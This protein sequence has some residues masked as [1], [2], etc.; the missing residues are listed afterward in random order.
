MIQ[1]LP[2]QVPSTFRPGGFL[3]NRLAGKRIVVTGATG[4]AAAG[5][6]AFAAEGAHVFVI[7][8]TAESC[9]SLVESIVAGG[10][11]AKWAAA[12]LTDEE[13]AVDAFGAA[14]SEL[15]GVDGLYAV[16]GGSG[17]RFGDGP[18]DSVPLDGWNETLSLNGRPAFLAAREAIRSMLSGRE[19]DPTSTGSIAI[20]SSV[21]AFAPSPEMFATHAYAAIKG[22]E[23]SLAVSMAAYYAPHGIRVNIVAPGLV[24]TPM[25]A[26]AA[27]D[28]G[29][30]SFAERKQPLVGGLLQPED[31]SP[32]ATFLMA[33]ESRAVTGQTIAVD[34]GWSVTDAC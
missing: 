30:V 5:A 23:I 31:L 4:I 6:I 27:G 22:A 28:P 24:D 10:G 25:A 20:V 9:A 3:T 1:I 12:D 8:R 33:D 13:E 26:R 11:S 16:A 29:I 34:G 19:L 14:T 15:G 7:S 21:L 17:R 32:L 2:L 18:L